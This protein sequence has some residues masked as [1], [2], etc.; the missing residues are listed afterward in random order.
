MEDLYDGDFAE[1]CT[2]DERLERVGEKRQIRIAP[3][4]AMAE[5]LLYI[6]Y[7]KSRFVSRHM[8][9]CVVLCGDATQLPR[10]NKRHATDQNRTKKDMNIFCFGESRR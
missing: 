7:K 9:P 2:V 4:G 6:N 5:G 10:E 3:I 8:H 1:F